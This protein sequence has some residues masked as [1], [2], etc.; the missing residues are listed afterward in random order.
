MLRVGIFCIFLSLPSCLFFGDGSDNNK[1]NPPTPTNN[2]NNT[3]SSSTTGTTMPG[4]EPKCG[5]GAI[6]QASEEC[7]MEA[8]STHT[9]KTRGFASGEL[10]CSPQCKI[11]TIECNA[12]GNERI[13]DGEACDTNTTARCSTIENGFESGL[14]SC[15]D[16]CQF[17]ADQCY[18]C[19]NGTV[20][21]TEK[22]DG[23]NLDQQTCSSLR[24]YASK[25]DIECSSSC[26][27]FNIGRCRPTLVGLASRQ[28]YNCGLRSDNGKVMCWGE[29][30]ADADNAPNPPEGEFVQVSLGETH[31]CAVKKDSSIECWGAIGGG[32]INVP[33]NNIDYRSVAAG[34]EHTCALKNDGS[35]KCWGSIE[36]FDV[37]MERGFKSLV[38]HDKYS[39][40]INATNEIQ[41]FGKETENRL[42][43]PIEKFKRISIGVNHGC[44]IRMNDTLK[45]WGNDNEGKAT[46]PDGKFKALSASRFH[47]CAIAM[48][49]RLSCWGADRFMLPQPIAMDHFIEISTAAEHTCARRVD[50]TLV[51]W[52]GSFTPTYNI[53]PPEID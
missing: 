23:N 41:C 10:K 37:P 38:S 11:E 7:D 1:N 5:D 44:G 35:I 31:R 49:N 33:V 52:R 42:V 20:E 26:L 6:N 13:D 14:L 50:N 40:A 22:C 39:C 12:C 28:K 53:T 27:D 19:G 36:T 8:F 25:G 15:S 45:C 48:D 34:K 18:T 51:C 17:E 4:E 16:T 24:G 21:G 2:T 32:K 43:A 47:T 3:T 46:P 29:P 9:C 30:F